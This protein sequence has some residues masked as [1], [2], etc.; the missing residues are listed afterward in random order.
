MTDLEIVKA[1]GDVCR[2]AREPGAYNDATYWQLKHAVMRAMATS[3]L[4]I[5]D[6]IRA[7][8]CERFAREAETHA[9]R[10]VQIAHD[11]ALSAEINARRL[12]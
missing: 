9:V 1:I 5:G 2:R 8:D 11:R 3:Y 10:C 12:K 6:D 4:A 7:D